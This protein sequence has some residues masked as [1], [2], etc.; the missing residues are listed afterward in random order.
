MK[1]RSTYRELDCFLGAGTRDGFEEKILVDKAIG[2]EFA[3]FWEAIAG[4][5]VEAFFCF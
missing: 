4:L 5:E 3:L 1:E 2:D